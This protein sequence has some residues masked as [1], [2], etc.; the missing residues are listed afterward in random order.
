MGGEL[1][2]ARVQGLLA[3]KLFVVFIYDAAL[4]PKLVLEHVALVL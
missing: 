2:E 1:G 4:V 3:L